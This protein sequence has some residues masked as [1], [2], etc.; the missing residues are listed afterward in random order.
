MKRQT[1][2]DCMFCMQ[3]G[4]HKF[5]RR[6]PTICTQHA[7]SRLCFITIDSKVWQCHVA[8]AIMIKFF[9]QWQRLFLFVRK[10]MVW[11]FHDKFDEKT[12]QL[13]SCLN[14]SRIVSMSALARDLL[15]YLGQVVWPPS[16]GALC[17]WVINAVRWSVHDGFLASPLLSWLDILLYDSSQCVNVSV[18][19]LMMSDI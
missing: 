13:R 18:W 3:C 16:V 5:K 15:C 4:R 2:Q 10:P 19:S 1:F 9:D 11:K 14:F 12:R 8:I 17:R 7:F 6:L